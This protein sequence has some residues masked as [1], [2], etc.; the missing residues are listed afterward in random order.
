M[1]TPLKMPTGM[2]RAPP[3]P[4]SISVPT[5]ALAMPPP[6]SPTGFGIFVKKSP[7]QR[8]EPL[9]DDQ[10]ETSTSGISA[11]TTERP[12]SDHQSSR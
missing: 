8:L 12:H 6:G 1:N 10:P 9:P 7:V 11:M 2:A 3:W 4:T 5:I